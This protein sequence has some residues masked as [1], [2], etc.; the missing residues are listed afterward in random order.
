MRARVH[1]YRRRVSSENYPWRKTSGLKAAVYDDASIT[2]CSS[3]CLCSSWCWRR[4]PPRRHLRVGKGIA[5]G[6]DARVEPHAEDTPVARAQA[7]IV[8][9][10]GTRLGLHV[11]HR[12]VT[13]RPGH[14]EPGSA[15]VGRIGLIPAAHKVVRVLAAVVPA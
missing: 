15:L 12:I 14:S 2:R 13:R 5:A 11:G 1:Y 3:W 10:E 9:D 6:A 8:A 4:C 7:V